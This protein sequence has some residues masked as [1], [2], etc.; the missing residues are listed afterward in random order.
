[1]FSALSTIE[2][3]GPMTHSELATHER[4]QPPTVTAIVGRLEG[5]GLVERETDAEDRRV[6]RLSLSKQGARFLEAARSKKTAYLAKR[7]ARLGPGD[8]DTLERAAIL[9]ERL[10]EDDS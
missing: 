10:M 9:L 7:L 3:H 2:R 1:M 5:A 6:S 8:R 4:V